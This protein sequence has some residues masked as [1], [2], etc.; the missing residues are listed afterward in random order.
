MTDQRFHT[1]TSSSFMSNLDN[2][3]VLESLA[4][5]VGE[6]G[7]QINTDADPEKIIVQVANENINNSALCIYDAPNGNKIT[8][9]QIVKII[10]DHIHG[11]FAVVYSETLDDEGKVADAYMD[12][13]GGSFHGHFGEVI[14]YRMTGVTGPQVENVI[15]VDEVDD[16]EGIAYIADTF[17]VKTGE[18]GKTHERR[19]KRAA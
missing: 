17:G 1:A 6:D 11:G 4:L 13:V 2:F 9:E 15:R 8:H 19:I 10:Q 16:P 14:S 18:H 5:I 3:A 7:Y 12:M